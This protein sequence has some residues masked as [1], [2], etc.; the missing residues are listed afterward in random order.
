MARGAQYSHFCHAALCLCMRL[1]HNYA[2]RALR[3]LLQKDDDGMIF[4]GEEYGMPIHIYGDKISLSLHPLSG[5][6]A[7]RPANIVEVLHSLYQGEATAR[8]RANLLPPAS[9]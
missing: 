7:T 2:I 6:H 3:S 9:P 1:I 5:A 4:P 8:V